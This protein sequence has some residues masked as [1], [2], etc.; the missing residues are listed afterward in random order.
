MICPNCG[1][2]VDDVL[3]DGETPSDN[4]DRLCHIGT[5][6]ESELAGDGVIHL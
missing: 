2:E 4:Y 6:T 3:S 5:T 1:D